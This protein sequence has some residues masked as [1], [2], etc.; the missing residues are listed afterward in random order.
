MIKRMPQ[1]SNW[2]PLEWCGYKDDA[3]PLSYTPPTT[4]LFIDITQYSFV[5][6]LN[7]FLLLYFLILVLVP[8]GEGEVKRPSFSAICTWISALLH[9]VWTRLACY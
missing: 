8:P 3:L 4:D 7:G 9:L 5:S 1:D 2:G 6:A